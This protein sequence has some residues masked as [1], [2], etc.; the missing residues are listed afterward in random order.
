MGW[1]CFADLRMV[2]MAI[3]LIVVART[4]L[5]DALRGIGVS[6]GT[7]PFA[8]HRSALG[9]FL[10]GSAWMRTGYAV[11]KTATFCGL[12]LARA[13]AGPPR[14]RSSARRRRR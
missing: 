4:T 8:Q 11:G 13:A 3:P 2:P 14:R 7:A 6:Q 12:A 1:V 9:R 10:V 5:T